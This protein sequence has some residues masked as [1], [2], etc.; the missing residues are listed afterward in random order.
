MSE[1]TRWFDG[2][3]K[4]VRHGV[5]QQKNLVG[6]LGYQRWDGKFWFGWYSTPEKATIDYRRAHACFQND[7]WRG[8]AVAP[9]EPI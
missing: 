6:R 5:Y 9:K 7:N 8:L 1:F 2:K 4:P 3:T